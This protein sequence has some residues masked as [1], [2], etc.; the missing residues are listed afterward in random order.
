MLYQ[1]KN[2]H[3]GNVFTE[4]PLLDFS[5]NTNPFGTPEWIIEAVQESIKHINSYPDPHCRKAVQ[6]IS[7]YENVPA[8]TILLGN[9]AAELIY[10]FCSAV[11]P[12]RALV[13]A[14]TFSEYENALKI[15]GSIVFHHQLTPDNDFDAEGSLLSAIEAHSPE[16]VFLCSPNNPTGRLIN[17]S[18][19]TEIMDLCRH[20]DIFL[21]LDECFLDFTNEPDLLK[22]QLPANPKSVI[23]KA[24][25]KS[26]A[27]AG[28]RIGYVLN[29]DP[30]LLRK[31]S[32]MTQPWNISLPAQ[33]AAAV[34]HQGNTYITETRSFIQK[35]RRWLQEALKGMGI[36]V[37]P[38]DANFLLFRTEPGLVPALRKEKI[39]IRNCGNFHGLDDNWYRIAVRMHHENEILI[40]AVRKVLSEVR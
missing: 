25:T 18:L 34:I 24:F 40:N 6:A 36:Y 10:S 5:V 8:D 19:L 35:E 3:G 38:S 14:P 31:M 9:G 30:G 37:C 28:L 27:L 16:A 29:S 21:F 23:L 2:G 15:S 1:T 7:E 20:K 39:A 17:S 12:R 33:A 32:R 11:H 4:G 13:T 22:D 26:Y